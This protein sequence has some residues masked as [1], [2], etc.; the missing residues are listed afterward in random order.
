MSFSGY[1]MDYIYTESPMGQFT[2]NYVSRNDPVY[3]KDAADEYANQS[4]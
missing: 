4:L 1:L 3:L 2:K